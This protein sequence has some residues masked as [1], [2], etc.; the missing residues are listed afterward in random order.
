MVEGRV[1]GV[2]YRAET[3]KKATQLGLCGWVRNLPD[4]RVE[5]FASGPEPALQS[6][7]VWLQQGPARA[8]VK[9]VEYTYQDYQVFPDFSVRFD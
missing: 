2:F 4:G 8:E 7:F 9:S 3:Q 6:L 5:V 1:Q